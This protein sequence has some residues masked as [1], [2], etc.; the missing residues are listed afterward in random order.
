M[1]LG[2]GPPGELRGE[3]PGI[4]PLI[5]LPGSWELLHGQRHTA[6]LCRVSYPVPPCMG[7]T[8]IG[9]RRVALLDYL[10]ILCSLRYLF[11]TI[12]PLRLNLAAKSPAVEVALQGTPQ[13]PVLNPVERDAEFGL[14]LTMPYRS[15]FPSR[16]S[17]MHGDIRHMQCMYCCMVPVL[18]AVS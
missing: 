12:R 3:L 8:C 11:F 7:P 6:S 10:S 9:T 18:V 1:L 4:H 5:V 15:D 13:H 2:G 16:R 14:L 17:T